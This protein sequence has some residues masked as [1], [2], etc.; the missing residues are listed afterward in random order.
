M[1]EPAAVARRLTVAVMLLA[2]LAV[3]AARGASDFEKPPTLRLDDA[4]PPA[5][6]RGAGFHVEESVPTDGLTTRFRL[7]SDVGTFEVRGVETLALRVSELPA[8]R[9]LAKASKTATFTRALAETAKRPVNA[10]KQIIASPVETAKGIP[11]G[12]G[13]FFDRVGAGG[14]RLYDTVTDD[15]RSGGART[16][17]AV[18]GTGAMAADVMG[19]EQERRRLAKQ[20]G[21][22]PY[23][24]NAALSAK[25]DEFAKVA[26]Y[27][28]VG[29]NTLI[30]VAV[31]ASM[32]ITGTNVTRDLVYD[33]PRGDL[34]VR[35]EGAL[36][37]MGVGEKSLRAL[38]AA[39]G[40]TLSL[41]TT[42][43]HHLQ[44]LDGVEGRAGVVALA[45]TAAT[46][47]QALFLVRGVRM[48]A[49]RHATKPLAKLGAVGTVFGIDADG[50]IVVPGAVDYVSWTE[51]MATFAKR[52]DLKGPTR[53][54]RITGRM[55]ERAKRGIEALGWTVVENAG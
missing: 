42:L 41:Q 8:L 13:R 16:K 40:F 54:I 48:L 36:R 14:K 39:P 18:R 31:P 38:Q 45:G 30:S 53:E 6:R 24:T 15:G 49:A 32:V 5:L 43:V 47:D 34:I 22:D 35:N 50:G 20:L 7:R 26:F 12:V 55:T 27:G 33:T 17:D 9:E 52:S 29:V 37:A 11:A 3:P 44:S 28:R 10:A 51:R 25:L 4:A 21:V 2:A 1:D 23:T 19:Y 46:T